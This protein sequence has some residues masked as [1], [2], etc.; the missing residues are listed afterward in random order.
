MSIHPLP[1]H[2]IR[3]LTSGQALT[4]PP[5]LIKELLDNSL[6]AHATHLSIELSSNTLDILQV[7]D[8]GHGIPP[9]D[10]GAMA[11]RHCTSKI[12]DFND[13]ASCRTLG[14]R[15]EALASAAEMAGSGM[16]IT[17]RVEGEKVAVCCTVDKTGAV[18]G[19]RPVGAAVGTT[20]RVEGFLKG[21]PV[22]RE[23]ALKGAPKSIAKLRALLQRYYL[24]HPH[25]RFSLHILAAQ[26][27]KG[28]TEDVVYAPSKT[29]PEAVQ[30]AVGKDVA[31]ACEWISTTSTSPEDPEEQSV[32]L[33]AFLPKP[34]APPAV[35]AKKPQ[36]TNFVYVD[37]RAVSCARGTLKQVLALYKTYLKAALE[38]PAVSDPF[39]Y[40]NIRC[41]P[42]SYDPNI[43]PAKDD[44]M[45]HDSGAVL[46]AVEGMLK[47]FYGELKSDDN[48]SSRRSTNKGKA[49]EVPRNGFELLLARKPKAAPTVETPG[50][51]SSSSRRPYVRPVRDVEYD[52]DEEELAAREMDAV[53]DS[54]DAGLVCVDSPPRRP[55][56]LP[57]VM[58]VEEKEQ[59]QIMGGTEDAE[60]AAAAGPASEVEP[61]EKAPLPEAGTVPVPV[62]V[63]PRRKSTNW[64]FNMYGGADDEDNDDDEAYIPMEPTASDNEETA[65]RDITIS[66]PWTTA[67]INSPIT[68]SSPQR[69]LRR[70]F[71]PPSVVVSPVNRRSSRGRAD[72]PISPAASSPGGFRGDS[73]VKA[74][75][76]GDGNAGVMGSWIS[77]SRRKGQEPGEASPPAARKGFV[78]AAK[79]YHDNP[80]NDDDDDDAEPHRR[81][82][83]QAPKRRRLNQDPEPADEPEPAL[84]SPPK[85]SPHKNR[86]LA[87]MAALHSPAQQMTLTGELPALLPPPAQ[88]RRTKSRRRTKTLLPLDAVPEVVMQT[89]MLRCS[90]AVDGT[91]LKEVVEGLRAWDGYVGGTAAA[92]ATRKGDEGGEAADEVDD[93]AFWC[94]GGERE[95]DAGVLG[96]VVERWLARFG[97]SVGGWE[98]R[99]SGSGSG[100]EEGGRV[101]VAVD[102]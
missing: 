5:S 74:R 12:R 29:V 47:R 78:S 44:V 57:A 65:Q 77:G 28:R 48:S 71:K 66:N 32:A 13:I 21:L 92:T 43:E 49:V 25:C 14:F 63:T 9:D 68:R 30:K 95:G 22:R 83:Q 99:G 3:A 37:S 41:P 80:T 4:S 85:S 10:R 19:R 55:L 45:F 72:A 98:W 64:G 59:D 53:M 6:D 27:S 39:V 79:F 69:Q 31:A 101:L 67:K 93:G 51:K 15:G 34:T 90:V 94:E 58:V 46:A 38:A 52:E 73:A 24:S 20:V 84:A 75:K 16:T 1:A 102:G 87:A 11:V 54:G 7:K 86:F 82:P 61:V 81:R 76:G 50:G 18:V 96:G 97:V 17:T 62:P 70:P 33:E 88:A 100:E 91:K 26:G 89:H 35:I 8:N 56:L 36:C 23:N 2:S 42:G 40:L 60:E